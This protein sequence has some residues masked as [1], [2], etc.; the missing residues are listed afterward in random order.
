MF[1]ILFGLSMNYEVLMLWRMKEE[2]DRAGDNTRAALIMVALFGRGVFD[3]SIILKA[4]YVGM[5]ITVLVDATVV[6]A[7]LV[8]ATMRLMRN[9]NWWA[10]ASLKRLQS[11]ARMSETA[12]GAFDATGPPFAPAGSPDD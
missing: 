9:V 3:R 4:M 2:Y 7:L 5:A 10:P 8:P 1:C 11:R 6:R 12:E